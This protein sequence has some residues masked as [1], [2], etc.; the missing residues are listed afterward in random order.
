MENSENIKIKIHP[1]AF[2]A[3]GEELVTS[4]SVAVL[5]LVKNS[6]DAYALSVDI[7][8]DKDSEGKPRIVIKDDGH[9]MTRE[10]IINAWATIATPYKK[11]NPIV[12][13]VIDGV[14]YTRVVSGNKGLGRFSAARLGRTMTMITKTDDGPAMEA[15]F[16]WTLFNEIN[17]MEDCQL[18]LKTLNDNRSTGTT[19][20]IQDLND[21]WDNPDKITDLINELSRLISPFEAINDFEI[22]LTALGDTEG[23]RVKPKKFIDRPTYKI[24]GEVDGGGTINYK[25]CFD[26]E[27]RKRETEG[28]IE[29][30]V[31]NY[32]DVPDLLN[33]EKELKDYTAGPFSFELKAWDMDA[34]SL[35][36]VSQRFSIGKRDIR[37]SIKLYK[38]ISV[39]RDKVL[40]LPKSETSRDWLGLDA[41]R[42]SQIGRRLSTNQIIGI[43]QISNKNNPEIKDT[44]DREKLADTFQYKQFV[45][46]M[47][48]VVDTLQ[49]ERNI[50]REEGKKGESLSEIL[51]PLSSGE[52]VES[53][54]NAAKNG[55]DANE[56]VEFI[57]DYHEKNE[58]QLQELNERLVYYAQTASLGSV[59]I[60]IMHEILT[61]MT[62]VKR[63]LDRIGRN[64]PEDEKTKSYYDGALSSHRRI[65]EVTNSF[66]PLY[67]RDLR[68]RI[69]PLSLKEAIDQSFNLISA[70]KMSEGV[71]L[72]NNINDQI[73]VLVPRSELQTVF[74]NLFDNSC[75]WLQDNE[76]DKKI[77]VELE[78]I[79]DGMC[80]VSINDNG[81]GIK[82]EYS[83]R[84]FVPGV[85]SKP[86]G[87]GMGLVIVTEIIKAYGGKVG[88]IQPGKIGGA[89]LVVDIPIKK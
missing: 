63:F 65:L 43:V 10:V 4:D 77:I 39:Y 31:E 28:S 85:T 88:V 1:R 46:A 73:M 13:R 17:R 29:W 55:A 41:K 42:I 70:K 89:S 25:Y 68:K 82:E 86:K 53:V 14:E 36:D 76:N 45:E 20:I 83:E 84:I 57:K 69:P 37:S 66:A 2:S 9:G 47:L 71:E 11:N 44:T 79:K 58:L 16:D 23:V 64:L 81:K 30:K 6:Y 7:R 72:Q 34:E 27:N 56:I 40:V 32:N 62:V 51:S 67:K 74:I 60:V 18:K 75:Y 33:V 21:N 15:F 22:N 59:A 49:R 3:L 80:R 48:E 87:I 12:K 5:E 38:G 26:N 8:F 52:L 24:T 61:G 54:E 50:D 35:Q 78:E 19:I